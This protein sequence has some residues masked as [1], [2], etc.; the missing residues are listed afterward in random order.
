MD[1][2]SHFGDLVAVAVK[3]VMA[4]SSM[5]GRALARSLGKSE[6]YVRDRL[7][8]TFEF[9]LADV[10][11]F[12]VLVGMSPEAFIGSMDRGDLAAELPERA[13]GTAAAARSI[14][15]IVGGRAPAARP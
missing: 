11:R 13:S 2:P 9:S 3:R 14:S 12:A 15:E 4:Q 10:E 6:G 1:P 5:S 8:G 7:N